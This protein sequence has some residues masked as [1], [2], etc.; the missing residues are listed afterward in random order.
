MSE[1]KIY[2]CQYCKTKRD[3]HQSYSY[4]GFYEFVVWFCFVCLQQAYFFKNLNDYLFI[5]PAIVFSI[6]KRVVKLF[7]C[8]IC[9]SEPT[10]SDSSLELNLNS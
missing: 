1:K 8:D 6:N 10:G 5:V 7:I 3:F 4:T 9:E 2:Y